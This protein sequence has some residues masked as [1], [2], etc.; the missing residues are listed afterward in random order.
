MTFFNTNRAINETSAV[1]MD[2]A[3][4]RTKSFDPLKVEPYNG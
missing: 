3:G 2:T 1:Q 4:S